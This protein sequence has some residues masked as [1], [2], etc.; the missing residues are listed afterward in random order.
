MSGVYLFNCKS[1]HN[2]TKN[3]SQQQDVVKLVECQKIKVP[4]G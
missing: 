2:N 4:E 1:S 3:G